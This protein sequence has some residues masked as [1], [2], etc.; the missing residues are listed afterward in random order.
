MYKWW[1]I[2]FKFSSFT[3]S[4]NGRQLATLIL[5]TKDWKHCRIWLC[6]MTVAA[7]NCTVI[8]SSWYFFIMLTLSLNYTYITA[9]SFYTLLNSFSDH[10]G[11]VFHWRW[12]PGKL[13]VPYEH[14]PFRSLNLSLFLGPYFSQSSSSSYELIVYL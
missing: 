13:C 7:I 14:Q 2:P 5:C 4:C 12:M 10:T 11:H 1:K 8:F 9:R 3:P 6:V